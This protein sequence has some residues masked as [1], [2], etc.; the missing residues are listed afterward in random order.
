MQRGQ[1]VLVKSAGHQWNN[2]PVLISEAGDGHHTVEL[3]EEQVLPSEKR[4]TC[5]LHSSCFG[6]LSVDRQ[7]QISATM[8]LRLEVLPY[9]G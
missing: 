5:L 2:R 3:L 7:Q 8:G 1:I 4:L 6:R 9:V